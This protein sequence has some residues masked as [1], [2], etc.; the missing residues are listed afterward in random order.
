MT[1]TLMIQIGII[2]A[3][4]VVLAGMLVLHVLQGKSGRTADRR[5]LLFLLATGVLLVAILFVAG[6][7]ALG[8]NASLASQVSMLLMPALMGVLALIVVNFKL[9]AQLRRGEKTVA[10]L[11]GLVVL[12]LLAGTWRQLHEMF[13]VI[14]PGALLLAA[15]WALGSVGARDIVLSLVAVV[16]LALFNA[17]SVTDLD[18]PLAAW[19]R[20]PLG[21][22]LSYLPGLMVALAA[23][24]ISNG[25]MRLSRPAPDG[26]RGAGPSR[27]WPAG[28]RW[29]LAALLLGYLA[30]ST[31]WASIWD[32]TS[33]GMLGL[34]LSMAIG[35]AAIAA[36][37]LMGMTLTGRRRLAGLAFAALVPLLMSGAFDYGWDVSYH[38]ITESRAAR[39][40]RAVE[41]FYTH[42][43]R[44]PEALREL[45]P[46]D[47][48]WIS[49]PVILRGKD[50]CYQ[51]GEDYYRL[52]AFYREYFGGPIS[53][54]IYA[55]AGS[56]PESGWVCE[57]ELAELKA[58]YDP[59]PMYEHGFVKPTPEELLPA[60]VVPIERTPV[61]PL[62]RAAS[63][64]LGNWSPDGE[65]L[66]F[67]LLESG[68][69]GPFVTLNFLEAKSGDVCQVNKRYPAMSELR[70]HCA[71]LPDGRLL[72]VS[73]G[74][75][76]DLSRPCEAGIESLAGRYPATFSRVTAHE[77]QSG[78]ILLEDGIS[79]WILDGGSLEARPVSGVSPNPYEFHWDS[80]AWSPGGERL[81]ISRMN[82]RDRKAGS[83]LY[84]VAGDTGEVVERLPLAYAADQSAP[85]VEW[86][87]RDE[88]L[89]HS[90][91]LLAVMDLGSDPPRMVHV[92]KDVFALDIAYPDE[93]SAMACRRDQTGE[94]YYLA[95]RVDHPRNQAVYMYHSKVGEVQV[96]HH[97]VHTVLFLPDGDWIRLSKWEDSVAFRDEYELV[98]MDA[99]GRGAR[100]LAVQG[101]TPRNYPSLHAAYLP[102]A[103]QMVF[104]SSQGVSL[105]SVP[106]GTLL[107]FWE[108]AGGEGDHDAYV[109][110]APGE[111]ALVAVTDED[112][113]YFISL[114]N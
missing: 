67:S 94:S 21:I 5:F 83:T 26:E 72:F 42:S 18:L 44:Y 59:P 19:L 89:V 35:M 1:T 6:Q 112:G 36:G 76:V 8:D 106:D 28:L 27:W 63:I 99:S 96:L 68:G 73:E 62:L 30:Y 93:I 103:S 64:M 38:A 88:L 40:Q 23:V 41:R 11:L 25:L 100:R 79:F 84:L 74:G 49:G 78:R 14:L 105:V 113:L 108:L 109:L 33:D 15:A 37:M 46:R 70:E 77:G 50:W 110:V 51:G 69:E 104:S 43:G 98:W 9:L 20:V 31:L 66:F 114:L 3:L 24:L 61:H 91:D 56:P 54:H 22:L 85:R 45:V 87:T 12:A 13:Y 90:A 10:F 81:A 111:E 65:Y 75:E 58:R 7:L 80:C 55:S 39:I 48:V 102:G 4:L 101:H 95:V 17:V 60:S 97:D 53:L 71:W 34:W 92:L 86:L 82:G 52:G 47:L 2:P 57:E 107:R 29:G 32:S 16:L